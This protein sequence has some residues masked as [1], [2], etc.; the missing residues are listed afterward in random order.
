MSARDLPLSPAGDLP[1]NDILAMAAGPAAKVDPQARVEGGVLLGDG[2]VVRCGA[3]LPRGTKL[4]EDV[5]VGPNAVFVDAEPGERGTLVQAGARIGAG[6]VI[7]AGLV[8]GA[9]ARVLPGAVVMHSVAAGATV[10]ARAAM[11]RA[12]GGSAARAD[13]AGFP[14]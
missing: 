10:A 6:A 2:C 13:Q 5:T 8:I 7:Y 1:L 9:G 4:E 14:A 11:A 12:V 3:Y